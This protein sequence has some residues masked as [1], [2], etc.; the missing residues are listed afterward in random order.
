M[1]S[2]FSE[3]KGSGCLFEGLMLGFVATHSLFVW[4]KWLLED[5]M[6]FCVVA[7]VCILSFKFSKYYSD[8]LAKNMVRAQHVVSK[9]S[10][11]STTKGKSTPVSI[12][13]ELSVIPNKGFHPSCLSAPL[14]LDSHSWVV[15]TLQWD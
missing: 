7:T 9:S 12:F 13:S 14:G 3:Y 2:R 4:Y 8:L 15:A 10:T 11:P 6:I 5:V 1:L